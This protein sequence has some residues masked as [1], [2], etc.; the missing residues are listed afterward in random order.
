MNTSVYSQHKK[1]IRQA[2][3]LQHSMGDFINN[4]QLGYLSSFRLSANFWQMEN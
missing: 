4:H 2:I 3:L 1:L